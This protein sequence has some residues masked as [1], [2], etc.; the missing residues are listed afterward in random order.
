MWNS[1]KNKKERNNVMKK[2]KK[3]VG[4]LLTLAMVV[5]MSITTFAATTTYTITAPNNNHTYE[6]YQIFTGDLAGNVLSNVKWGDNGTG[7]VGEAVDDSVLT[8]LKGLTGSNKDKLTTIKKYVNL[9]SEAYKTVKN[10]SVDV[11]AGY[12]LIKDKDNS[13]A[14]EDDAYTLYIVK[15]SANLTIQP[16]AEKPSSEKKVKDINDTTGK[17]TTDA[18]NNT[19]WIDSADYDIGDEVPFQLTGTVASDYDNYTVYKFIFRDKQSAGLTFNEDSVKVYVGDS[20]EPIDSAYY[21]VTVTNTENETFNV[22][23]A[24]LKKIPGVQAGS[25][26]RVE[27]TSTLNAN[28]VLGAAGNPNTMH[29]EYSNNPNDAQGGETGKTPDDTV[30]VF[31]YK[32]VVNKKDGDGNILAGADFKLEKKNPDGTWSEVTRKITELE[33]AEGNVTSVED[34]TKKTATRFTFTGLDDGEYRLTETATPAGYNTIAP[35]TFTVTADHTILSD[36]PT[37]NGLTGEKVTGEITLAPSDDKSSLSTDIVNKRG[38]ELP[39]TGGMGTTILYVVGAIL[40]IGA[41]IL[42]VTKKRMGA[43]K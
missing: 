29:L 36:N 1:Y 41:G 11:D 4:I 9:D 10:G 5:A 23:F 38:T 17:A 31:T 34:N 30:I 22:S 26:I 35:I 19:N 2:M 8:E 21:T 18:T 37:L 7:T 12:Y 42:L 16:K 13:L 25:K 39:S 20:E 40:V 27:Y 15:V 14:G 6:I 33:D 24:D 28:A 3:L 43:N 32:L